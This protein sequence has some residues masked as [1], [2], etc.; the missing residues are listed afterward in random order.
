MWP[1]TFGCACGFGLLAAIAAG[2]SPGNTYWM[3]KSAIPGS[4]GEPEPVVASQPVP[5]KKPTVF[6][7]LPIESNSTAELVPDVISFN[8]AGCAGFT[9]SM[10]LAIW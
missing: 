3:R 8:E 9:W 4:I 5:A 10:C 2:P 7:G 6:T 1:G